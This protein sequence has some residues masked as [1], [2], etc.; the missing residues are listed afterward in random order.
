MDKQ[1]EELK[2]KYHNV[3]KNVKDEYHI[4]TLVETL[5]SL[6][7]ELIWDRKFDMAANVLSALMARAN[8]L[9]DTIFKVFHFIL[10][11]N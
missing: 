1:E 8:K 4:N 11:N 10:F 7:E 2:L 5:Q 3:V 9:P 6:L